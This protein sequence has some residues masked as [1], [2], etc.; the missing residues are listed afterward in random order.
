MKLRN[1]PNR[2]GFTEL[3]SSRSLKSSGKKFI[4]VKLKRADEHWFANKSARHEVE[5]SRRESCDEQWNVAMPKQYQVVLGSQ[6]VSTGRDATVTHRRLTNQALDKHR[7]A[8]LCTRRILDTEV[9]SLEHQSLFDS[10]WIKELAETEIA[11]L[12]DDA[13]SSGPDVS[14]IESWMSTEATEL[15]VATEGVNADQ[16]VERGG[17]AS[18]QLDQ[19]ATTVATKQRARTPSTAHNAEEGVVELRNSDGHQD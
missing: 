8:P 7:R 12:C 19:N 18:R 5:T 16:V 11:N 9:R 15:P 2:V 6:K 10:V 4:G 14:D 17:G 1:S 13:T 3:P